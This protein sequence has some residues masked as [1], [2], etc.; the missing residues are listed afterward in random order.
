MNS[1]FNESVKIKGVPQN[2][3]TLFKKEADMKRRLYHGS[4]VII[5]ACLLSNF[6][7]PS[8][9]V[10]ADW[11]ETW[12]KDKFP[13]GIRISLEMTDRG[14]IYNKVIFFQQGNLG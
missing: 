11:E 8:A 4:I 13:S 3:V 12:N 6:F 5:L 14:E 2:S 1:A 7:V 10:T 9:G